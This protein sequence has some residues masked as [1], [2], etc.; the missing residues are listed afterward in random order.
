MADRGLDVFEKYDFEV[1]S[2]SKGRGAVIADT[3][4]G[5]RMLKPYIGSGRHL[6]WCAGMLELLNESGS[7][8]TDAYE[9]NLEG[10]YINTSNDGSR[11]IVKRWYVC[12]DCD[13]KILGDVYGTV[14]TLAILH[15]ELTGMKAAPDYRAKSPLTEFDRRTRELMRIRKYLASKHQ[16]NVFE[17]LAASSCDEFLT[18]A[19]SALSLIKEYFVSK[20]PKEE[21]CHGDF[22]YHNICFGHSL[23]I[24]INFEKMCYGY[25]MMDL[26]NFMR[27]ILEKNDWD[28]KLGYGM[29]SEYDKIMPLSES[30]VELIGILFAYPEKF[31]K[32]LNGYFNSNKAW[33]PAKNVD[34]LKQFIDINRKRTAFIKTIH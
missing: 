29:L 9:A 20:S 27:K 17:G 33:L 23:P 18:E 5:L 3:D 1:K 6:N 16:K 25:R 2:I 11:Y 34:K 24:V 32:I 12:R 7:I 10:E 13:I 26:Y 31:W 4:K 30:D 21:L 28:I 8:E 15:K 22:N 14:R 19:K